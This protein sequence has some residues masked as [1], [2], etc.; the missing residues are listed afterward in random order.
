MIS[1]SNGL[2]LISLDDDKSN[3]NKSNG[4]EQKYTL[5]INDINF[6]LENEEAKQPQSQKFTPKKFCKRLRVNL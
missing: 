6:D 2:S 1:K 5:K 3:L 4:G